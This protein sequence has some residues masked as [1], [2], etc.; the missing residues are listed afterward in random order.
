MGKRDRYILSII[1]GGAIGSVAGLILAPDK[2]DKT[3]KKFGGNT[4]KLLTQG[5]KLS[6]HVIK[7]HGDEI[8]KVIKIIKKG[9]V[10]LASKLKELM[11]SRIE[12]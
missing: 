11:R 9:S 10:G 3:R 6:E 8:N 7:E 2:G 4:M 1:L 12:R 5:K